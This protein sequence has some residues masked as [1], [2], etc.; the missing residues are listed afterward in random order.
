MLCKFEKITAIH[1]D[2]GY[3]EYMVAPEEAVAAM[4][5]DLPSVGQ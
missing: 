1:F 3:A 5:D 4:P 2:G